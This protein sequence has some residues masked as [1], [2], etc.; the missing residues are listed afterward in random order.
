[1]KTAQKDAAMWVALP[2]S[3]VTWFGT[4]FFTIP[5]FLFG[6]FV[7]LPL[8]FLVDK[9]TRKHVHWSAVLWS[10]AIIAV[11]PVWRMRSEGFENIDPKKTYLIVC[12]HQSMLDILVVAARLPILFKFLAKKEL[13]KLPFLG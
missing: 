7:I 6:L 11:T 9:G 12:N 13:F 4:I 8:S 5:C 1:M 10:R 3:L 2:T